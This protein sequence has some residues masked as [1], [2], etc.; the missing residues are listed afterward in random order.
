M[1]VGRIEFCFIGPL[2]FEEFLVGVGDQRLVDL[3]QK[4]NL[5]DT[6]PLPI[7]EQLLRRVKDYWIVGGMPEAVAA[8]SERGIYGDAE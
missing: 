5:G 3:L 4:F 7:H 2:T 8:F 6:I 1:P